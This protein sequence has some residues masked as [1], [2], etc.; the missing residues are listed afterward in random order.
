[1]APLRG[2][3]FGLHIT[4]NGTTATTHVNNAG[5][6]TDSDRSHRAGRGVPSQPIPGGLRSRDASIDDRRQRIDDSRVSGRRGCQR[7][8]ASA[9]SETD[10]IQ[11]VSRLI[12]RAPH[13]RDAWRRARR[14]CAIDVWGDESG[15]LLRIS[16]PSQELEYVREDVASVS[17]RRVVI[18]RPGDEQVLIPANGFNL[19]GTV[20]KA[21]AAGARQSGGRARRRIGAARSGRDRRRHSD[22]RPARRARWPTP[23]SRCCATTSAA[24]ARA[25]AASKPPA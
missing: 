25:A 10:R 22:F 9:T 24:S 23:A 7:R 20:S 2:Q 6:T 8:S 19:A 4:V 21:T 14:R 16:V 1:M 18:S 3:A 17:S 13:A 5:Q 11:T 15:R 12:R